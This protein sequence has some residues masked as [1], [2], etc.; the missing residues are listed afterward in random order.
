MLS[1]FP[2]GAESDTKKCPTR[3]KIVWGICRMQPP[4]GS[5]V[6]W[7]LSPGGGAF[8]GYLSAGRASDVE[9]V[10]DQV[11]D[12]RAHERR[13]GRDTLR[14]R[15]ARVSVDRPHCCGHRGALTQQL[16][17]LQTVPS[18]APELAISGKWKANDAMRRRCVS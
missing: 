11:N 15:I 8:R 7:T 17:Q 5:L 14:F 13:S 10:R 4:P 3:E 18:T 16:L 9:R 1:R 6:S 12:Q 2:K